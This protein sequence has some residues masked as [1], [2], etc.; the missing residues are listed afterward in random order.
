M[1][2]ISLSSDVIVYD[3]SHDIDDDINHDIDYEIIAKIK[4]SQCTWDVR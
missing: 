3:I 4:L 2:M 1:I